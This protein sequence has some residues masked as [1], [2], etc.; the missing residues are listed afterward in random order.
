MDTLLIILLCILLLLIFLLLIIVS[1]LAYKL[2]INSK[3]KANSEPS[4]L[5]AKAKEIISESGGVIDDDSQLGPKC[6]DHPHLYA[7]GICSITDEPYCELC[8]TKE[9]DIRFARKHISLVMDSEWETLYFL[10]NER[11][12][13][14]KLN[15]L[16]TIKHEKWKHENLPLIT[17]KQYKINI[18]NDHIETYTVVMSRVDDKDIWT[19]DL[20]F[21]T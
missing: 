19:K 7:K 4:E 9:N 1:V 16:L 14:D 2:L 5:L 10:Q 20:N 17:Q 13:A 15:E 8:I 11:V 18:E 3:E 12:G 21:L 6:V